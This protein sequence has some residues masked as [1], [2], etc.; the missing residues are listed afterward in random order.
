MP[1]DG[2]IVLRAARAGDAPLMQRIGISAYWSNFETLEP[3]ASAVAG[4]RQGVEAMFEADGRNLW[5]HSL[6]AEIDGVAAGWGSRAAGQPEIAEL[7]VA[8]DRQGRGIGS[9]LIARFLSDIAA[10]GHAAAEI[11]THRRNAAAIRLYERNGF[12]AAEERSRPSKLGRPIP[13]VV[14]RRRL[15]PA[16]G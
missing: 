7:W 12:V 15:R 10:E 8:A 9:A 3:G 11:V 2:R 4:Y 6:I 14:L 16:N 5:P 13:L 1:E